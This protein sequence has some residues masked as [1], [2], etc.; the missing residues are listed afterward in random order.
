[1]PALT[2]YPTVLA[3]RPTQPTTLPALSEHHATLHAVRLGL[4][5]CGRTRTRFL[6]WHT[7]EWFLH[8]EVCDLILPLL[9][10]AYGIL[11]IVT[12]P[13]VIVDLMVLLNLVFASIQ[14]I[15]SG[16]VFTSVGLI[17]PDLA[18]TNAWI[19]ALDLVFTG[20]GIALQHEAVAAY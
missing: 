7:S 3:A 9:C 13:H 20:I 14:I 16:L 15:L 10:G 6:P 8:P 17:S 4:I 1:M 5:R 19:I 2:N 12:G 11:H 18:F